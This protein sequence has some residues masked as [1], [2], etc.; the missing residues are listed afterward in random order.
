MN[1]RQCSIFDY[2]N[3][4]ENNDDRLRFVVITG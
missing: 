4:N 2:M 1:A 3:S